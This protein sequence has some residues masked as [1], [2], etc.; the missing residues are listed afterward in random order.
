MTCRL[1]VPCLALLTLACMAEPA[2]TPS[3]MI[4]PRAYRCPYTDS[5]PKLDGTGSDAV[6]SRAEWSEEFVD[7][8]GAARP[9]PR[10]RTRVKMLWDEGHLYVHAELAEPHVWGTHTKRNSIIFED[11]DFEIFIDPDGD[12]LNYYEFEINPLGTVMELT[13]PKPYVDKGNYTFVQTPGLRSA[14]HVNGTVNDPSDI[15]KSWTVEV[16]MPLAGLRELKVG[17][18]PEGL[19]GGETWRV[20][21]SRVQWT[22]RIVDGKYVK[23]PKAEKPEDNWVWSPQGVVDMHRPEKWGRVTFV[24]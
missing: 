18:V 16:A 23:V 9:A 14:V 15:D 2:T 17:G 5:P 11:N 12:R 7:I 24:K 8:E 21:F 22:H 1:L 10:Y 20:N 6:W 19:R 3:S 13:L 4:Q